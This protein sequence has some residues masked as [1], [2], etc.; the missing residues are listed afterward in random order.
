MK[1]L[2][3]ILLIVL[4]VGCAQ[5]AVQE[6][7]TPTEQP[8][9]KVPD[10]TTEQKP[11]EVEATGEEE[12]VETDSTKETRE[13][14]SD[15]SKEVLGLAEKRVMSLEYSYFGPETLPAS[16]NFWVKGD[17]I[18]IEFP[19][20]GKYRIDQ[21][22]YKYVYLDKAANTAVVVCAEDAGAC[23]ISLGPQEIHYGLYG[24]I[25]TP[26]EWLDEIT[27]FEIVSTEN[28]YTREVYRAESN[29]GMVWID[30]YTGVPL[31][32]EKDGETLLRIERIV[33]NQVKDEDVSYE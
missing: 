12:P 8:V 3:A 20:D 28:L 19:K 22:Y 16:Y 6:T 26:L 4:L 33:V 9:E 1:Y 25:K 18:K 24:N 29:I 17:K 30:T 10:T 21:D 11:A 27:S 13:E 7:T 15:K 14:M 31:Q 23:D 2:I 5:E 32:I